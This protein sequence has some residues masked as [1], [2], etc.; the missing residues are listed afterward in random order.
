MKVLNLR[1]TKGSIDDFSL[2]IEKASL[3]YAD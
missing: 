3:R 1:Y 2:D